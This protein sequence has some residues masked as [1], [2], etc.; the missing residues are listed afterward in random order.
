MF[1]TCSGI[2]QT[3]TTVA[4]VKWET[5]RVSERKISILLPKL[6]VLIRN[7]QI[8]SQQTFEKFAVFAGDS[9]YGINIVSKLNEKI[10]FFCSPAKEFGK[11]SFPL[12]LSEIKNDKAFLSAKSLVLNGRQ[13]E[14]VKTE[15]INY[16]LVNDFESRKWVEIWTV[17][18]DENSEVVKA[19]VGSLQFVQNPDGIEIGEGSPTTLGDFVERTAVDTTGKVTAENEEVKNGTKIGEGS[20]IGSGSSGVRPPADSTK[21]VAAKSPD[22]PTSPLRIII[23]PAPSYTDEARKKGIQGNVKLRITFLPNGAIGGISAIEELP[24]GLTEQAIKAAKKIVFIPAKRGGISVS[25]T[26]MFQYNF[27]IF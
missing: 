16:W 7:K 17:N 2:S 20:G 4:P 11:D 25:I 3:A 1:F 23:K 15:S 22:L 26:K 14:F 21:T 5:Y 6:P 27:A 9:V 12:R 24:F 10:P 18:A 13:T 8:C 19:F